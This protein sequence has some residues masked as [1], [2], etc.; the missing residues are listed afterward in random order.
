MEAPVQQDSE[1]SDVDEIISGVRRLRGEPKK[2]DI[3]S[4][5]L[6]RSASQSVESQQ[7]ASREAV[8]R[9]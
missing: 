2:A 7:G 4:V 5:L 6:H 9:L 3:V 1:P 8:G